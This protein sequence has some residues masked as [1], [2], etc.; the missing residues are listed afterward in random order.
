[1]KTY[2]I[3]YAVYGSKLVDAPS[4]AAAETIVLTMDA[5]ELVQFDDDIEIEY[6]VPA[7]E[8]Q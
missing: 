5:D 6:V 2:E 4:Q 7:E 8:E 3:H 1:M